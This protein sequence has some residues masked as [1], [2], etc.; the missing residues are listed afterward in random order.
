MKKIIFLFSLGTLFLSNVQ[1]QFEMDSIRNF[2]LNFYDANWQDTLDA[3]Y[4]ADTDLMVLATLTING[5]TYDSV[6]VRYKGN[7]SCTPG[8]I[9]NPFHIELDT[10]KNQ[11][12]MGVT[13]FKLSNGFKDPTFVREVMSYEALSNYMDCSMSNFVQLYADGQLIGLYNSN[14]TINKDF[15][16][17]HFYSRNNTRFKCDPS[18]MGAPPPP[19]PRF[20]V[21]PQENKGLLPPPPHHHHPHLPP[22]RGGIKPIGF[23]SAL[24]FIAN[25]STAYYD[26]YQLKSD[27][28]WAQMNNLINILNN[29]PAQIE[30]ILDVDRALWMLAWNTLFANMDSYTGSGHNYYIYQNDSGRFC[31]IIWDLNENFGTFT[32]GMTSTQLKQL[33]PF[34]AINDTARPLIQKLLYDPNYRKRY[35]AHFKTLKEE[36]IDTDY[37]IQRAQELQTMIDQYVQNDP[38][39]LF[40][41]TDFQNSI[42][43]DINTGTGVIIGIEPFLHERKT[44]LDTVDVLQPLQPDIQSVTINPDTPLVNQEVTITC[45]V[46]DASM[47][48]LEYTTSPIGP[49]I[50]IQMVDDGTNGDTLS[51]DNIFTVILPAQLPGTTVRYYFYAENPGAGKFYPAHAEYDVLSYT[52]QSS[53]T[54][55]SIVINEFCA[56]NSTTQTDNAGEYDDWIELYNTGNTDIQLQ[57]MYLTD[58]LS[59]LFKWQIPDTTIAANGF[60]IIWADNDVLQTNLHA[61]FK[62]SSGGEELALINSDG[63]IADSVTFPVQYTD[64]TYG[65]YPNGTG[66]FQYLYPTYNAT[67]VTLDISENQSNNTFKI[68]PNPTTGQI[69]IEAK[70]LQ[71]I[72]VSDF[73]GKIVLTKQANQTVSTI[74]LTDMSGGVYFIKV[75]T[76]K[77]TGVTK[78]MKY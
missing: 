55:S 2:Y 8:Q 49:F 74:D 40:T 26:F 70:D 75:Q 7:S 69:T 9:K 24:G 29:Y 37:F 22:L 46:T 17:T 38:N 32:N 57:N 63:T 68:F 66:N 25:D 27:Y 64:T 53:F 3:Y 6:G 71:T 35:L 76:K 54:G 13:V 56:K 41:Y 12:F 39:K 58:N 31:P 1:A 65:R 50:P 5:I 61:N 34:Y 33:H 67:N 18:N 14:Q 15:V 78:V 42:T 44:Y 77:Y 21:F 28:G 59:D 45:Q 52:V 20:F 10:I 62:L 4:I 30:T 23:G 48:W 72:T 16:E 73:T 11:D 60:L 51:G 36:L 47:V 43:Q 19:P